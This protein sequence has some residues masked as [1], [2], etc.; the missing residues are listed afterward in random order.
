M[1]IP[2]VERRRSL[3]KRDLRRHLFYLFSS[4]SGRYGAPFDKLSVGGALAANVAAST[5]ATSAVSSSTAAGAAASTLGSGGTG[6][7]E[8]PT[9]ISDFEFSALQ[10]SGLIH[11]HQ[12]IYYLLNNVLCSLERDAG[13]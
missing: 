4:W 3:L 12:T 1:S 5:A 2:S 13:C 6:E 10:V 7:A 11:H 9:A 8:K